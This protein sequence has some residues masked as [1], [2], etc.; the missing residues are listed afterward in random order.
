MSNKKFNKEEL[1]DTHGPMNSVA[2][3]D[4][5]VW[6][7]AKVGK[8]NPNW[9]WGMGLTAEEVAKIYCKREK[10]LLLYSVNPA[11]APVGPVLAF[12]FKQ[13]LLSVRSAFV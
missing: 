4:A 5:E 2:K 12:T 6:A 8:E 13:S 10:L 9:Y 11:V 7:N 3:D 1:K